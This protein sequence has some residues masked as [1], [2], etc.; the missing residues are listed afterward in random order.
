MMSKMIPRANQDVDSDWEV[1]ENVTRQPPGMVMKVRFGPEVVDSILKAA[2]SVG[3]SPVEFA[4][5]AIL[6]AIHDPALQAELSHD[7]STR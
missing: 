1:V 7:G 6:R 4:R 2:E 3:V 5:R